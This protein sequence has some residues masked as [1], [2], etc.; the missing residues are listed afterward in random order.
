MIEEDE[1]RSD[2]LEGTTQGDCCRVLL[3]SSLPNL[4]SLNTANDS[5]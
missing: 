3:S 1:E 2:I 5:L 4:S